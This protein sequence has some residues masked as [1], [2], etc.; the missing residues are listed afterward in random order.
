MKLTSTQ[1]KILVLSSLGGVLEF[2]DF[3]IY[4]LLANYISIE[5]FPTGSN[6]TSLIATF[7]TFTV[8][9]LVRPLGGFLFGHFGDKF[10]RKTTFTFSIL[11]MAVATTLIGFVPPYAKIGISAP[12]ILT[13][14]RI[15]QGLSVGG[16]I[17]GAIAYVSES[18]PEKKGFA[19]GVI[20]CSINFGIVFGS[21]FHALLSSTLSQDQMLAWGWRLPFYHRWIIWFFEL[22]HANTSRRIKLV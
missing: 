20:F 12:I 21:L 9:Y 16:E 19:C 14:L 10:G 17:P 7:A 1:N 8:G 2:Y 18:I 13:F 15:L 5:F 4:A 11:L 22:S 3:I 6:I